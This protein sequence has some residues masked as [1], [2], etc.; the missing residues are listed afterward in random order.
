MNILKIP[1]STLIWTWLLWS[2]TNVQGETTQ[3]DPQP[4][5][6]KL[7][8][9]KMHHPLSPKKKLRCPRGPAGPTGPTGPKGATGPIGN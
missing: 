3:N 7:T 9:T 4:I 8:D 1:L 6:K 5:S 2:P